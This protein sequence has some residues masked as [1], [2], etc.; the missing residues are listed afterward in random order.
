MCMTTFVCIT[1]CWAR[2]SLVAD[3]DIDPDVKSENGVVMQIPWVS[4]MNKSCR[5]FFQVVIL[6]V[7]VSSVLCPSLNW[8]HAGFVYWKSQCIPAQ[9]VPG[10]ILSSSLSARE[11]IPS[12]TLLWHGCYELIVVFGTSG[13]DTGTDTLNPGSEERNRTTS[14]LI[15]HHQLSHFFIISSRWGFLSVS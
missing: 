7:N 15:L 9:L 4:G 5:G 13:W 2:G 12:F 8:S 1:H 11:P 3:I 6:V 10:V 14:A